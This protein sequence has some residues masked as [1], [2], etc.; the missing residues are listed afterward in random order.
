MAVSLARRWKI[1][2]SI[3]EVM[4]QVMPGY[5]SPDFADM[6]S[7]D[8]TKNNVEIFTSE[9]VLQFEGNNNFVNYLITDKKN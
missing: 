9:Q 2:T 8:L 5:V 4:P 3:I 7:H 6:L 1:K